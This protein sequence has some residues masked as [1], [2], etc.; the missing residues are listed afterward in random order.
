LMASRRWKVAR[1]WAMM[2]PQPIIPT[3]IGLPT[4]GPFR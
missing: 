2:A 1:Y 3:F 4:E